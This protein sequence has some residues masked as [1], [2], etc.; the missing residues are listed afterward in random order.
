MVTRRSYALHATVL[1][2]V[3]LLVAVPGRADTTLELK[4]EFIEAFKHA[5]IV[6]PGHPVS[7]ITW[8]RRPRCATTT[9]AAR[10]MAQ[11]TGRRSWSTRPWRR[12]V[13]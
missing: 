7:R 13:R 6:T 11:N 4:N 12:F 1:G 10:N 9:A 3:L 8:A 2:A 5:A